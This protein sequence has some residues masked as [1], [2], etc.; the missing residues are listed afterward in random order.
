MNTSIS[1]FG[2][3]KAS[4]Y[5]PK[6]IKSELRDNLISNIQAGRPSFPGMHG[7]E[8]TV[9]PQLERAILSKHNINLLGL[10]GQG[11]TRIARLM[12]NLLDEYIP[13]IAGSEMNDDP[14]QPISR[15]ARDL[16]A[17]KGDNTP[18]AWLHRNDRF[19]EKLATPMNV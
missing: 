2:E 12:V 18:I 14:F 3:L 5:Q 17:E 7:Y 11:K 6:S 13:Y 16:M 4:G 15:F 9:I 10:R 8:H 19:A 1:T